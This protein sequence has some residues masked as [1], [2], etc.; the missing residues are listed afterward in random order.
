MRARVWQLF[1]VLALA[2]AV[3]IGAAALP[4]SAATITYTPGWHL[5]AG[6]PGTTFRGISSLYAYDPVAGQYVSLPLDQATAAGAGYFAFFT[7]LFV[8]RM[9]PDDHQAVSAP[10][11][12]GA[13]T[14]VG[15]PSA[16]S[17]ATVAGAD[18]VYVYDQ[19]EGYVI[20]SSVPP[21]AGALVFSYNGGTATI[22][23]IPGGIDAT[24]A[25]QAD[26]LVDIAITPADM[27]AGFHLTRAD[28][29]GGNNINIPVTYVEEFRPRSAPKPVDA[30]Q[31]VFVQ[32]NV[33][34]TKDAAYAKLLLDGTTV[35]TIRSIFGANV[36]S[37]DT[38]QAPA[39]GDDAKA[40]NVQ[41][42]NGNNQV[43]QY[44]IAFRRKQFFVTVVVTAPYGKEDL[45][46][47]QSLAATQDSR[48]DAAF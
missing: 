45:Q 18:I 47:L 13:W 32:I 28:T 37:V 22:T 21:G 46:L 40:F 15:N 10:L 12:A 36:K 16:Y 34:Q 6:P 1:A 5:V 24:I 38:P 30:E 39:V 25:N 9:A 29:N 20:E 31:T 11:A 43:G 42:V 26:K 14:L 7:D 17:P 35:P 2:A 27:P 3:G 48:I 4:V 23:P 19:Q 33:Q 8:V 44:L 41:I